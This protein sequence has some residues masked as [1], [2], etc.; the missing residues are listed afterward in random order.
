MRLSANRGLRVA[1][2]CA[3]A[4]LALPALSAAPRDLSG[5]ITAAGRPLRDAV[6]WLDVDGGLAPA[7]APVRA[8]ALI[9]QRNM[10]FL[11]RVL[12]VRVGTVVDMPNSDRLFHN[13]FSFRDGKVFDLGLYP[14]GSSKSVT[15]DRAGV[16]RLF[17]NI[18]P[19]MA[20]YVVA[21]D[22]P[23]FAVTDAGG[24]FVLHGVPD[25]SHRYHLWRAGAAPV[26]GTIDA[27]GGPIAIALP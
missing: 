2:V 8:H 17:C 4:A 20:A 5:L 25:G 27:A 11:P 16:S 7:A 12:A 19:A 6:L 18:H 24:R 26:D 9:D 15:F 22:S 14:V 23:F 13:V 3:L 10:Q 21:V 1:L